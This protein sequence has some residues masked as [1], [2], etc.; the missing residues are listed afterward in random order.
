ME[1]LADSWASTAL[2]TLAA[3]PGTAAAVADSVEGADRAAIEPDLE[4]MCMLGLLERRAGRRGEAI[5]APTK[6]LREGIVLLIAAARHERRH[7]ASQTAPVGTADVVAAYQLSLSLI[8]LPED[9]SGT[10]RFE[11]EL[12]GGVVTGVSAEVVEGRVVSAEPDLE[13]EAYA[14]ARGKLRDWFRAVIDGGIE[15]L[16]FDDDHGLARAVVE[17]MH[18][19]MFG[20]QP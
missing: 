10:C 18:E 19:T 4:R 14:S 11:L 8:R 1:T 15:S 6:W 13:R 20:D 3:R 16:D 17:A 5:Y 7:L 2:H 12:G 9:R